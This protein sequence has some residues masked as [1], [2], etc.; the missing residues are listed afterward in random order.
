M[1]MVVHS[2]V[3]QGIASERVCNNLVGGQNVALVEGGSQLAEGRSGGI[4][5][6]DT[7]VQTL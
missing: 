4:A 2:V 5:R 3:T 7:V 6:Q 1:Y